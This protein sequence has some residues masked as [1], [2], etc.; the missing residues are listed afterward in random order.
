MCTLKSLTSKKSARPPYQ[1]NI[2][3]INYKFTSIINESF[4]TS[5]TQLAQFC[6]TNLALSYTPT[7]YFHEHI[8]Q[9]QIRK[10]HR[11]AAKQ[12]KKKKNIQEMFQLPH[13]NNLTNAQS[14]LQIL[15]RFIS[16]P[17][18]L[19]IRDFDLEALG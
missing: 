14:C 11:N 12:Y 9:S 13:I 17:L 19:S 5:M 16:A 4:K 8:S 2:T 3:V 18:T 1:P 6:S 15:A 10:S 7:K